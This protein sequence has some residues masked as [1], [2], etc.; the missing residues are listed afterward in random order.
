MS[1]IITDTEIVPSVPVIST[2]GAIEFRLTSALVPYAR[3]ARLHDESHVA[4]IAASIREWGFTIP[5]VVDELD[6]IIAGHGRILAAE[7]LQMERVPVLVA[8]GWSDE[9]KRAY[10]LADNKLALNSRWDPAMLALELSEL[11]D[12]FAVELTGFAGDEL[13]RILK[14]QAAPDDFLAFDGT[15]VTPEHACPKCG[16]R[17]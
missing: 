12:I 17:F 8:R 16:F 7:K 5:V 4:Q 13:E 9:K 6:G 11:R 15:N 2:L 1:E 3:N 10:V 14:A